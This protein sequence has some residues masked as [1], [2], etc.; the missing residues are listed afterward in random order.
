MN[1]P[2]YKSYRSF[3]A[4]CALATAMAIPA[5]TYAGEVTLKSADGTVNLVGEFIEFTDNN[6]VIRTGLGDLRISASRVSCIGDDCPTFS[7]TEADINIGGSDT[8]AQGVMPLLVSGYGA[9]LGADATQTA[10]GVDGQFLTDMVGEQGFGDPIGSYLVTSTSSDASFAALLDDTIQV[11]MS[12][13]RITPDEARALRDAGGG[14]MISPDQEHII[15]SDS[16]VFITHPSNPVRSMTMDQLRAVLT[17][18]IT[19]WSELGGEDAKIQLVLASE[20]TPNM[21]LIDE[22]IFD[23]GDPEHPSDRVSIDNDTETASFINAN[24]NALGMVGYAF[25]RGAQPVTLINDCGLT[26]IPEAFSVRTEEYALQRSLYLYTRADT[27]TEAT[28]AFV[29]Y[30]TSN[31]ADE[32]IAK[33][34]F[35]DLGVD[36]HAQPLDGDR[37]KALLDPN[38]D[39]YEAGFMREMLGQMVNY[40]RLST[41]FRFRTGSQSLDL[42][43]ELNIAR[44]TDYLEMQPEGTKIMFV[45]FTDNVGAFDSNRELSKSRADQVMSA[46]QS[47]A[48]DRLSGVEMTTTGFGSIAP[49]ACNTSESERQVNRRVEVWIEAANG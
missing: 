26:M 19:N 27:A 45:G 30:A 39:T 10:T 13:R 15:A 7:T 43:G 2:I 28:T 29:D 24:P 9:F 16:L 34:G 17:G 47:Y 6:Y 1:Q 38:A 20:G 37:A 41:T 31:A 12:A 8:I 46:L 40:D 32:V 4:T 18:G 44:L 11:G 36:R 14:Q 5:A 23:F 48:S 42:R 25:Q 35:I 22:K 33:A 21:E 49:S 3:A